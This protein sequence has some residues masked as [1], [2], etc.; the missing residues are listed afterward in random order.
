MNQETQPEKEQ[1]TSEEKAAIERREEQM[2]I[3]KSVA[4]TFL[5]SLFVLCSLFGCVVL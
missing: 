4:K 1:Q 3:V 5:L 2:K